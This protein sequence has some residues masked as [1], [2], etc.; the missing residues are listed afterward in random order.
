MIGIKA[1]GHA[2]KLVDARSMHDFRRHAHCHATGN[3]NGPSLQAYSQSCSLSAAAD[4]MNDDDD[5]VII[6]S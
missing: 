6:T 1:V 3:N 4:D 2:G 5:D